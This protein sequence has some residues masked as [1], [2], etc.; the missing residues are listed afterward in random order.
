MKLSARLEKIV[1]LVGKDVRLA[2]IGTDH[3]YIPIELLKSEKINYAILSDINKGPLE[4]ARKEIERQGLVNKT[5][6]RLG[7]GLEVLDTNEVDQVIIAGMGGIL[8][9]DLIEKKLDLCKKLDKMILQPMQAQEDLREYLNMRGFYII[10]E[11]LVKEDFRLYEIMEVVYRGKVEE[12]DPIYYEIPIR[13]IEKKDPLLGA[14][15][16]KKLREN[17]SILEKLDKSTQGQGENK[18]ILGRKK[19]V[20]AKL[21]KLGQIYRELGGKA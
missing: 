21:N 16:E 19:I 5:D 15:L 14:L 6:L 3:G 12:I 4:N 17:R 10:E 2:D 1:D 11:H 18:S 20:E 13:L 7:S 9:S 8:I